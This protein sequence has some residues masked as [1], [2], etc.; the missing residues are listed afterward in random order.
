MIRRKVLLVTVG[1][2]GD[3]HPFIAIGLALKERGFRP[4]MAVAEDHVAKCLAAG[5]E[6]SAVLPGLDAVCRAMA[7]GRAAAVERLM[8]SQ[9]EMMDSVLMPHLAES[10]AA[11]DRLAD[12]ADVVVA[13]IFAF[14]AAMVAEKRELPLVSVILQ[15]MALLSACDPPRTPDFREMRPPPV[16]RVGYAWNRLVYAAMRVV[17]GALY[18][19]R[20]DR[21]RVGYGLSRTG[22][23]RL[24]EPPSRSVLRLACYSPELAHLP[25]DA[26]PATRLVGFPFFDSDS[27]RS[28]PL[29]GLLGAFLRAGSAPLVFTL[30]TFAVDGSGNFYDRAREVAARLGRRAVLLV[31]GHAAPRWNGG[32]FVCSYA[33]HSQLFPAAAVIVHH[34][35]VGTTGQAMRAGKPQL[36]VPHMGDQEDHAARI[37]RLGLG[38]RL[39]RSRFTG[40]RAERALIALLADPGYGARAAA[41][42]ARMVNDDGAGAAAA[43]IAAA[44]DWVEIVRH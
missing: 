41:V 3:L 35:G 6:A 4:V 5:L 30:G 38:L 1:T 34:G 7:L 24:L 40:S 11:L 43:M 44:L 14:A 27:G 9:R 2:L 25:R 39:E 23:R 37:V 42:A 13:S 12:N 15:P 29:P 10:V 19:S 32:V 28:D 16:G 21:V 8:S 36:V 22:A 26:A 20:I 17:V 31:G 33:P 18:G